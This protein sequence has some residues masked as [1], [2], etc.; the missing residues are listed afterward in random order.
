MP[1]PAAGVVYT[2]G[3]GRYG[4][5]GHGDE[6]ERTVPTKCT[7][8]AGVRIIATSCGDMHMAAVNGMCPSMRTCA[9]VSIAPHVAC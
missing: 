2:W 4:V 5:L 9:C 1:S 7:A 8:L 3:N 6:A